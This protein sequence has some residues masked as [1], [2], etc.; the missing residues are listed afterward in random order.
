VER[1]KNGGWKRPTLE[2]AASFFEPGRALAKMDS[3]HPLANTEIEPWVAV[4]RIYEGITGR[5]G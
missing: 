2:E 5:G 3:E 1:Q 4:Q